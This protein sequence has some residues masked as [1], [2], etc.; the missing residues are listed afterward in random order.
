MVGSLYCAAFSGRDT[1]EE[2][3]T[4][5]LLPI[6]LL[7]GIAI[8]VPDMV[9]AAADPM[10]TCHNDPNPDNRIAACGQVLA[11][12]PNDPNYSWALNSRGFAHYQK[13]EMDLAL[14]DYDAAIKLNPKDPQAYNNRGAVHLSEGQFPL[15]LQDFTQA[16]KADPA[17]SAAFS[18]RGMAYLLLGKPEEALKDYNSAIKA[19]P[20]NVEA[21]SNRAA[22]YY[23]ANKLDL[24]FPDA[25]MALKLNPKSPELLYLR[26]LIYRKRED[27][28][29]AAQDLAAAKAIVPDIE[30]RMAKIG[31]Q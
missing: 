16:L 17:D 13:T 15:A 5:A 28:T 3:M 22:L 14:K 25:N 27:T 9:R 11:A 30:S 12:H 23:R 20:K 31:F 21:Y 6:L 7:A 4:R 29:H 10:V 24:A 18:N 19:D 26:S 1:I 2:H 8:A